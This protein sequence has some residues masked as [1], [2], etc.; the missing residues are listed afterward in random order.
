[1]KAT[2]IG[3]LVIKAAIATALLL[4]ST[5]LLF[6]QE[7]EKLDK[8]K[9]KAVKQ[10]REFCSGD[11]SSGEGKVSFKDLREMTI[12]AS[13]SLAVDGGKNGGIKIKGSD[14][15]D[16]L[17]RACVQ[18]WGT[19][20][21]AARAVASGIRI[22]TGGTIKAEASSDENWGVSYEVLVPRSTDLNLK[23]HNGG[24]G[25]SS[26]EGRIEFETLN[27][28]VSLM[29]VAGDVKGRTTNGGV[30]VSLAGNS[31]RGSG[32]DVVTTNG[33]VHLSMPDSYAA[34]IE[35]GTVNGGFRSE[36]AALS[37]TQEDVKGP[38]RHQ[39]ATRLN[40]VLNGGGAPIRV[41][42][43]NGG[44]NISSASKSAY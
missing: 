4:L 9:S 36:I 10:H 11:N 39:R 37:V 18:T 43:T 23:A 3:L 25:I 16:I 41:I 8:L 24:I 20:D 21:E 42:T 26:V 34:N 1:M 27:G 15:S 7:N 13:S 5:T 28:G 19:T 2:S 29:D 17:V 30:N 40:T 22:S 32:L 31:W 35:T 6:G 38:G 33:G 44:I 12:P 14:R